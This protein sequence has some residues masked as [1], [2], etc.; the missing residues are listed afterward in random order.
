MLVIIFLTLYIS[1]K[2]TKF[3][4]LSCVIIMMIINDDADNDNNNN[5]AILEQKTS[6]RGTSETLQPIERS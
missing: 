1:F 3:F 2:T 5:N 4:V 6:A